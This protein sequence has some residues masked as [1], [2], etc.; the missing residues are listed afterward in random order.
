MIN[1]IAGLNM[2]LYTAITCDKNE[3]LNGLLS[4]NSG[5]VV[6]LNSNQTIVQEIEHENNI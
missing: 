2:I 6:N 3:L 1:L 5:T 4:I